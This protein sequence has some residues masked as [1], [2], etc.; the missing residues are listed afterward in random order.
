MKIAISGTNDE[1]RLNLIKS[2][3]SQWPMYAMPEENIFQDEIKLEKAN[4][5]IIK[6][7]ES[8]NELEKKLFS[9]IIFFENQLAK[10][11]DVGHI[12]Y[13]GSGNDILVN[14]LIL[15]ENNLVSED[16]VEKI[17][18]HNKKILRLLDVVYFIPND[19][20]DNNSDDS[21]KLL[22][23]VYWNLYENYQTEF[24]QSPFFDHKNCASILL[25]ETNSPIN[26]IKMLLDK[27][28]NIESTAHGGYDGDLIDSEKL[29][30]VFNSNPQLLSAA[31]ESLK[32]G[33]RQNVGSITF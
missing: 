15:C 10:Y 33:N 4:G 6:S 32:N 5:D 2:F 31:L 25:L 3:I 11:K 14:A 18:Y 20:V 12:I 23:N 24:D 9:K 8:M 21:D 29:K 27:N 22:E 16:F 19:K 30:Q 28:G 1:Q 17:I 13:N 7:M 26:E